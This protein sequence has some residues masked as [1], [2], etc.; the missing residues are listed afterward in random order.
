[1]AHGHGQKKDG[2]GTNA[3]HVG[4]SV[5]SASMMANGQ[6]NDSRGGKSRFERY[7]WRSGHFIRGMI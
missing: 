5:G 1:M 3:E 6:K 4:G 7:C 2:R